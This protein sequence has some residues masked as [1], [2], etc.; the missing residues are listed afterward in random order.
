M[1]TLNDLTDTA[2]L[3]GQT[4]SVVRIST[5]RFIQALADI[6]MD[7][8]ETRY[9]FQRYVELHGARA[10]FATQWVEGDVERILCVL[11]SLPEGQILGYHI[12]WLD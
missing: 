10:R 2:P 3:P 11:Q 8:A 9:Y 5:R 6:T 1:T 7:Q 4:S 12:D